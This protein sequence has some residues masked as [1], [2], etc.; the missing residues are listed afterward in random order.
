MER[1]IYSCDEHIEELLDVYLDETYEMPIM[2]DMV[3]IV[4]VR[5]ENYNICH[6]CD[7]RA[8]YKL[9]GSGVKVKWL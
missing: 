5:Y 4:D 3:D 2:E 7:R 6:N 1:V 8:L 9:S